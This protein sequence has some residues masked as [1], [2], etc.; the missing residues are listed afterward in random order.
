MRKS[1]AKI[2]H[3]LLSGSGLKISTAESCTAGR[4]AHLITLVSGSSEYYSGGAV[5]YS[6]TLKHRLLGVEFQTID[7]FGIVSPEVASAMA[8]GVLKLTGSDFSVATTGWADRSGDEHEPAGTVWIAVS[9]PKGT[10]TRRFSSRADRKRNICR[11]ADA[12]LAFLCEYLRE[13]L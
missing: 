3:D 4:I 13:S 12:A 11:F 5:T 6:P 9:G 1:N 8:E 2:L 10:R 7:E